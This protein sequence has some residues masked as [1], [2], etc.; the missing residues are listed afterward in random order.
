MRVLIVVHGHPPT[1]IGGAELRAARTA[2]GLAVAGH[3]SSVLCV[4][5]VAVPDRRYVYDDCHEQ[6]VLVR[7]ISFRFEDGMNGFRQSYANPQIGAALAQFIEEWHPDIIHLFSGYLMSGSV[8]QT[9]RGYDLPIVVSLTDYWW[10]CHRINL[11]RTDGSRCDGPAPLDCTRC[12]QEMY[13][14]FRLPAKASRPLADWFWSLVPYLPLLGQSLGLLEQ[15]ERLRTTL[16]TLHLADRLISPSQALAQAYVEHGIDPAQITVW[17]QGV[18]LR[19]CPLR[20]PA[21]TLR[22]GYLGQIKSHKGVHTLIDAWGQLKGERLRSLAIYG[23]DQGAEAYG[24]R[25]RR[26][27]QKF[28]GVSWHDPIAHDAVWAALAELDVLVIPSRWRENSP[29]VILEAQA[30]GVVVVGSDLGGIAELV[31]HGRNGLRFSPDDAA[32]LAVQF[33]RL[34]DEPDLVAQLRAHPLPF[35][36]F[37]EELGQL[38]GLYRELVAAE[39]LSL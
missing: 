21:S 36:S 8:I 12:Y 27:A 4:E 6:G 32:D 15:A 22:F 5:S 13:R 10:L 18:S 19:A 31:E 17:R 16:G 25:L 11:V 29:N 2:R 35:Y 38:E 9:A 33:Q 26:M 34:L 37:D 30:M 23:S 7:R 39:M 3:A 28:G 14:R 24:A 1:H 20:K